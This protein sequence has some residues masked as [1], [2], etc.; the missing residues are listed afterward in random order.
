VGV[1]LIYVR[2]YQTCGVSVLEM[3]CVFQLTL[4]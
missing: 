3:L 4:L 2:L 1:N